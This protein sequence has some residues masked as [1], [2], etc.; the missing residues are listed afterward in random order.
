VV[1]G[2][3]APASGAG[4]ALAVLVGAVA[5][6]VVAA[7]RLMAVCAEG[8][9]EVLGVIVGGRRRLPPVDVWKQRYRLLDPRRCR[10]ALAHPRF[11][12]AS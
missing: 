5:V 8:R 11:L 12:L 2:A 10:E 6:Q 4:S 7:L 1:G 3:A 9:G